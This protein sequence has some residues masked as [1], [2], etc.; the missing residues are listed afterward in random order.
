MQ[1]RGREVAE[2]QRYQKVG[3]GGGSWEVVAVNADSS[4]ATHAKMRSL[5]EPKTFRTFAIEAVLDLRNFRLIEEPTGLS[6]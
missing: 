3:K 2:G 1:R 5:T 4:G 6:R